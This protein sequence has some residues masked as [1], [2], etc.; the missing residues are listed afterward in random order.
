MKIK[1]IIKG[2][3]ITKL[4]CIIMGLGHI[5]R[6][7]KVRGIIYL[8]LEAVFAIYIAVFGGR[9]LAMFFRNFFTGGNVGF[10]QTHISSEWNA[11]LG[12]YTKIPG[13]NSFH[14]VLYGI[15]TLFVVLFF[16]LVWLKSVKES[17]LLEELS[18]IGKKPTV[19]R[20]DIR[21]Y[22][23]S[24][25]HTT[26][27]SLPMIGLFLFTI[28]PLVT[29]IMIAFTNYDA[30][31]EVPERL[32][33]W[34]GVENFNDMLSGNSS[35]G[36][37]FWRVLG[38]TLGWAVLATFTN[39]FGG[40]LLAIFINKKGIRFKRG[41]RTLFVATIAVPQFVSLMIISK[42][43]DTGGG[44]LGSGGGIITQFVEKVF[45]YH[46]QFGLDIT[47][48][49]IWIIIANMWIGIPF[50]M[51][52]C[53]GILMNIPS[54]LYESARID[55][56]SPARQFCKITLPYMLF[57]TGPYLITQFIGN[58]NN[59]NVIYLLSGGGPGDNIK[60]TNGAKGTDLLITW[61]YKL[62]LG[63]DR[64]YKLASVIGILVFVISAVFS[65]VVYNR[66]SA[67]QG[68]GNFQ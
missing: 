46:L 33:Q 64:N 61:L 11:E 62:S 24:K 40:M 43:L 9:Y 15:L 14:V 12:E 19:F 23:D 60:Y 27:L 52:L 48:T 30:N 29:M 51:L 38:W 35:L 25:F 17:V 45:N 10:T 42:M 26:L 34:V 39:Y 68:E 47:T 4:S 65:L 63:A 67:V 22:L 57:V 7:Q 20:D 2:D 36:K 8:L 56:A 44:M 32:F 41:Y 66:S 3:A 53:S 13:D 16:A 37:T 49:R 31:H 28:V 58:I 6:G 54:D 59:F 1:K 21:N 18:I 50:S 55:G 5:F